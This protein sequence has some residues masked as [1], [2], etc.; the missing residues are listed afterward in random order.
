[1]QKTIMNGTV[2]LGKK[3]V[4]NL[5]LIIEIENATAMTYNLYIRVVIKSWIIIVCYVPSSL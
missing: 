2:I 3:V 4:F 1:M 5:M